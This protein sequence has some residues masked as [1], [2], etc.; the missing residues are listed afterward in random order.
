M[1][2]SQLPLSSLS[3]KIMAQKPWGE[4]AWEFCVCM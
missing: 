1:L 2:F 3:K 4:N